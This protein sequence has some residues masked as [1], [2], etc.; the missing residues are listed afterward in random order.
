ML[1]G[2]EYVL[3]MQVIASREAAAHNI[4]TSIE[5]I[6]LYVCSSVVVRPFW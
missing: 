4:W 2:T 5:Q 3:R 6:L 1:H